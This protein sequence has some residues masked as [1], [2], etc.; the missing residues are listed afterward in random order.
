MKQN[1]QTFWFSKNG[2]VEHT[3]SA[4][5]HPKLVIIYM[6][7]FVLV[8]QHFKHIG[9][10]VS[11]EVSR[12]FWRLK[13]RCSAFLPYLIVYASIRL[14]QKNKTNLGRGGC[15]FILT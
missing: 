14:T 6:P 15:I 9:G 8:G 5:I 10:E 7:F 3:N 12:L 13:T 11:G 2:D 1:W 4:L